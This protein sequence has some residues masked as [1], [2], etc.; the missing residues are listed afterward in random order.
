M[1]TCDVIK[2]C[3]LP[4]ADV[5]YALTDL[6]CTG[7]I[8]QCSD[9]GTI[10]DALWQTV[11]TFDIEKLLVSQEPC[12]LTFQELLRQRMQRTGGRQVTRVH[13]RLAKI[14]KR[15]RT[16]GRARSKYKMMQH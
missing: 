1:F 13:T 5:I 4:E 14:C 7:L 12:C 11:E 8:L 9:T 15:R 2:T 16:R 3:K 10:F 6:K